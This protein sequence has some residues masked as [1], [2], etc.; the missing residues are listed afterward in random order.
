MYLHQS[1]GGEE[2]REGWVD[3]GCGGLGVGGGGGGT[4]VLKNILVSR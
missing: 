1:G 3:G 4:V 2:I